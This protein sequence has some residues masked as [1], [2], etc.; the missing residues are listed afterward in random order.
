MSING[1]RSLGSQGLNGP[2]DGQGDDGPMAGLGNLADAM[3]VFACGLIV[4]LIAHYGVT[5]G[6]SELDSA[7]KLDTQVTPA[8]QEEVAAVGDYSEVGSI[9][10]DE[11]TGDLYVVTKKGQSLY[12]DEDEG[13]E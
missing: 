4:A 6:T 2:F 7:Q 1:S 10:R 5:L 12:S 13:N 11:A 3:L 8:S 9:F